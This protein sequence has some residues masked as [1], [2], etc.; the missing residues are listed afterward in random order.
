MPSGSKELL[1]FVYSEED[2]RVYLVG[3][4]IYCE[5]RL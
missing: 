3:R 5:H 1:S 2:L 4:G